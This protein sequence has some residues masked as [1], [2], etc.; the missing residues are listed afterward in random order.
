MRDISDLKEFSRSNEILRCGI[1]KDSVG[2]SE[3]VRVKGRRSVR[4]QQPRAFFD[5]HFSS[6]VSKVSLKIFDADL[7][8]F[9]IDEHTCTRARGFIE[10]DGGK[11]L[12]ERYE[13]NGTS[14]LSGIAV[15]AC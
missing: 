13:C 4:G 2:A 5:N 10:L 8:V 14:K 12:W 11:R 3:R 7:A 1:I 9:F 6:P 15:V